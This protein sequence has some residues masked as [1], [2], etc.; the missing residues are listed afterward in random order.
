[1]FC[2]VSIQTSILE[3]LLSDICWENVEGGLLMIR[4]SVC[5]FKIQHC[6]FWEFRAYI[7]ED[8]TLADIV[9]EV[10]QEMHLHKV[11]I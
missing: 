7:S 8:A 9:R 10:V 4:L 2:T 3:H 11:E 6:F 1:M 5:L